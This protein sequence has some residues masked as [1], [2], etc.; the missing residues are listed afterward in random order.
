MRAPDCSLFM[1]DQVYLD[2][3]TLKEFPNDAKWL[4]GKF[5]ADYR[6]SFETGLEPLLRLAPSACVPDDHEY[7][8]NAPHAS[9]QNA[10]T[11]NEGGRETWK[12]AAA[13]CYEAFAKPFNDR[14]TDSIDDPLVLDVHPISLFIADGRSK[15]DES[16]AHTLTPAC[17]G[18]LAE[19]IDRLNR[20]GKVGVFVSGQSL[21]HPAAS[22]VG[23]KLADWELPNYR[24]YSALLALLGSA[25]NRLLLLTGD[26]HWGRVSSAYDV[27]SGAERL[28]E[29]IV[30]PLSLVTTVGVDQ[31]R[32]FK[33]L[34][35][36]SDP[37]PRHNAGDAPPERLTFGSP[38]TYRCTVGQSADVKPAQIKGDQ[39]G[40]LS[41]D[42][43]N[44]R[45]RAAVRYFP[46][47]DTLSRA[48]TVPLFDIP[49]V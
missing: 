6:A 5:E 8:N 38:R 30:S 40:L 29:V 46:V 19:W 25:K 37:W 14:G 27:V 16:L 39:L 2:L 20:E 35:G 7:W 26:V 36:K 13:L 41:F 24:D 9:T 10:N 23:G 17:R 31:W 49:A 11:W 47:H 45:L 18:K 33:G 42:W 1:G 12:A 15:R 43:T 22:Q 32:W 44:A 4:A 3:P 28:Q 34:F 21:L 48:V